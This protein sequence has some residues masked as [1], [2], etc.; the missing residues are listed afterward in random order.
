MKFTELI[1]ETET[2]PI[3]NLKILKKKFHIDKKHLFIPLLLLFFFL[4]NKHYFV[5]VFLTIVSA[6]FSFYHDK[7][8]RTNI[9]L[10]MP[11][12]FSIMITW[13][14]GLVYT[15]IFFVLSDIIPTLLAGG[16]IGGMTLPFYMW[17][18]VVN[19]IV[20]IFP[21]SDIIL[22]GIILVIIEFIGSIIIKSFFGIPGFVAVFSSILSVIVRIIYF[23]TLGRLLLLLFNII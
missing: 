6:L 19:A 9:D 12:F 22:F 10:K 8:N 4:I 16:H 2:R 14:Y 11:L 7:F 5:F 13:E 20:L 17:F 15:L 1:K 18:F 23:S 21:I 3:I